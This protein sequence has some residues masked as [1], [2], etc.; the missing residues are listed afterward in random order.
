[1]C[2]PGSK[3][4]TNSPGQWPLKQK[5]LCY[6]KQ[7]SYWHARGYG[8]RHIE[9]C[10]AYRG[11]GLSMFVAVHE[12]D[13]QMAEWTGHLLRTASGPCPQGTW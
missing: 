12:K 5:N 13:T 3:E 11:T 4:H 7:G 1:M 9:P 2:H 10:T 8:L 6:K